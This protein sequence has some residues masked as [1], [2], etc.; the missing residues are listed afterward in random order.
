MYDDINVPH[1]WFYL[2]HGKKDKQKKKKTNNNNNKQQQN[3]NCDEIKQDE[4]KVK[5]SSIIFFLPALAYQPFLMQCLAKDSL[6]IGFLVPEIHA[7]MQ[8]R[9]CKQ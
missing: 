7:C 1:A 3:M 9:F 4:S 5:H 2:R 6:K 8:L